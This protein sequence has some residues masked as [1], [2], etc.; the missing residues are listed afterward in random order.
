VLVRNVLKDIHTR[1]APICDSPSL[2][3]QVLLAHTIGKNR[4]WILAHP[5][6][7]ISNE[8]LEY[9]QQSVDRVEQG[10]PLPYVLGSWEFYGLD[11]SVTPDTLIPRPETEILVDKAK[12]WLNDHPGMRYAADIGTGSGCI[13]ISLAVNI[14][15]LVILASDISLLALKVAY[16]NITQLNVTR[17][18]F[19]IAANL[20]PPTQKRFN[21][22]C[23]NLPYIPGERLNNLEIS[24][25]EPALS[26]DG[27]TQGLDVIEKFICEAPQYLLDSGLILLEIDSS[28]GLLVKNLARNEFPGSYIEVI[29]DLSGKDRVVS[30]QTSYT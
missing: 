23:A 19:P 11:F 2:D 26:L 7:H 3:S 27:G 6:A 13:A 1:L 14:Q 24:G 15:D 9:L 8:Q 16:Q 25:R 17:R 12:A 20:F 29:T 22:I 21:L 28:Q 10:D 30:I 4:T 18:V 5:D